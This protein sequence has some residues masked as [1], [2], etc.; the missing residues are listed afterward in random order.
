M[1]QVSYRSARVLVTGASG[2]IA[3][4]VIEAL[5]EAGA[6]V[7]GTGRKLP[8]RPV[9]GCAAFEVVD[10]QHPGDVS[11]L[12]ARTRPDIVFHMASHVSGL[13]DLPTVRAT[14][15]G[16]L[17]ST[18]NLLI[19]L[20][21]QGGSR[22]VVIAGSCEE[23]RCFTTGAPETAPTSPYAASK[24]AASAYGALFRKTFGLRVSHARI[25]MGY[26]PGQRDLKKL[27]P[28]VILELLQ[29]RSPGLSSGRR[30]ADFTYVTDIAAG[31]LALGLRPDI[32][33]MDIGSGSLTSVGEIAERLRD[34]IDPAAAL[35]FGA[36]PDRR[37]EPERIA[38]IAE[39]ERLVGW[40]PTCTLEAGL[41]A[42]VD[43]YR[44]EMPE[45]LRV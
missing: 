2:F 28:Y 38:D 21:E 13:Q 26:G 23:P 44:R 22:N 45:L 41:R 43:W 15:G 5:A 40:R 39:A 3:S 4:H 11:A 19:A 1:G 31:I 17:L 10:Y 29:G 36:T 24:V 27:V 12:I 42:T 9:S 35:A 34:L 14:L 33:T 6:S 25:F 37:H 20:A 30:R 16:N 7:I 32:E 8:K 18:V